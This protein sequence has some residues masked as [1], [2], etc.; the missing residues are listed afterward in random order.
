MSVRPGGGIVV[1]IPARIAH[2]L[3]EE[4]RKDKAQHLFTQCWGCVR[5]SN[6]EERR[7]CYNSRADLRGCGL[8]NRLYDEGYASPREARAAG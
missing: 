4:I 3:C 7:F 1:A 5:F 2:D 8:I 6:G